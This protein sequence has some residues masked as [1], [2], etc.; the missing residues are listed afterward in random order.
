M[1]RSDHATAAHRPVEA[2][3]IAIVSV[4]VFLPVSVSWCLAD[5]GIAR[6]DE[7][8]TAADTRKYHFMRP[9]EIATRPPALSD[10]RVNACRSPSQGELPDIGVLAVA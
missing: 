6:Y 1:V 3:G 7:A 8:T 2:L 9:V 10:I 5:F 4:D